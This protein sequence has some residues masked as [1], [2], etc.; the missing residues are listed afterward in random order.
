MAW[1]IDLGAMV[2]WRSAQAIVVFSGWGAACCH[3]IPWIPNKV[4]GQNYSQFCSEVQANS[5]GSIMVNF[6]H[7]K[8]FCFSEFPFWNLTPDWHH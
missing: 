7:W 4:G 6:A 5:W 2:L 8:F 1:Q 3:G